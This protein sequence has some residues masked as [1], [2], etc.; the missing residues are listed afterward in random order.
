MGVSPREFEPRRYQIYLFY[1]D[2][3]LDTLKITVP[4]LRMRSN[5]STTKT[6]VVDAI[7]ASRALSNPM[8]TDISQITIRHRGLPSGRFEL[9]WRFSIPEVGQATVAARVLTHAAVIAKVRLQESSVER[10]FSP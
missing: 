10:V 7:L 9:G 5:F 2:F 8:N 1:H 6:H 3:V 4:A